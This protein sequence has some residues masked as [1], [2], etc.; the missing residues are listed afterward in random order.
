MSLWKTT[1]NVNID[2]QEI[3]SMKPSIVIPFLARRI[4]EGHSPTRTHRAHRRLE[5]FS[6]ILALNSERNCLTGSC[7]TFMMIKVGMAVKKMAIIISVSNSDRPNS[8]HVIAKLQR[9]GRRPNTRTWVKKIFLKNTRRGPSGPPSVGP[10]GEMS[11]MIGS[12]VDICTMGKMSSSC[13]GKVTRVY[14]N[15]T[16]SVFST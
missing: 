4:R 9:Q 15:R 6:G 13:P 11:H 14:L 16:N 1:P 2:P 3:T 7:T 5:S 12:V 8:I 10:S